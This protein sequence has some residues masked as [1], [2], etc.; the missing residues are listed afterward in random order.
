M[1]GDHSFYIKDYIIIVVAWLISIWL[2]HKHK[3]KYYQKKIFYVLAPFP[4]AYLIQLVLTWIASTALST[5]KESAA[6]LYLAIAIYAFSEYVVMVFIVHSKTSVSTG[7]TELTFEVPK[8]KQIELDQDNSLGP[9]YFTP[10]VILKNLP[11]ILHDAV[12][13]VYSKLNLGKVQNGVPDQ[14][15][16]GHPQELDKRKS[17]DLRLVILSKRVNDF[18]DI[19]AILKKCYES[20]VPGG[21]LI[22]WYNNIQDTDQLL[23]ERFPAFLYYFVFPFHWLFY[24]VFSKIQGVYNIQE[25][26]SNGHNKVISWVEVHG[27]LAYCG[28]DVEYDE[29]VN[30]K[31]MLIAKKAKTISD[32]PEP[33]YYLFI[34]LNRVSLYGNIIRINKVRSMYPYSE[35]LQKKIY[36]QNSIG[37]SGKFVDD[38]RITPQGRIFRKYWIDELPQLMDWLRGSI[39]LVGIR[40]MSQ[41]FF[42]LYSPQYRQLFHTVKPGIISPIFDEKTDSFNDIEK[43]EYEYLVKYSEHPVKTDWIYFWLTV[44]NIFKGVRSK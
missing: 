28:F 32:N 17:S 22:I 9:V 1:P 2:T 21:H 16:V 33:S 12:L 24:R 34:K 19:N 40:A 25:W 20:L 43:I 36:E 39:K 14:L 30:G 26:L 31:Q 42:S 8:Y 37:N 11:A 3:P 4:K 13:S 18:G 5:N 29:R 23:K 44:K 41:H 38:P 7:D 27:R 10:E 15:F 35:F 6:P